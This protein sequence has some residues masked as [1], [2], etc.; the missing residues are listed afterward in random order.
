MGTVG[1]STTNPWEAF[2]VG[3]LDQRMENRG[4]DLRPTG[5]KVPLPDL[6]LNRRFNPRMQV[7]TASGSSD[8]GVDHN[9]SYLKW[10][11]LRHPRFSDF[12]LIMLPLSP[13]PRIST[14]TYEILSANIYRTVSEVGLSNPLGDLNSSCSFSN[15]RAIAPLPPSMIAPIAQAAP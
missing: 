8:R 15:H 12:W 10:A 2:F 9:W 13:S 3:S 7:A 14:L 6:P 1:N 11:A 4:S 5:E